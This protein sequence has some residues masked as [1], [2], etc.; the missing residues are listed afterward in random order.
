MS[1]LSGEQFFKYMPYP[2]ETGE[3]GSTY[4]RWMHPGEYEQAKKDGHFK[5]DLFM[6]KD[7]QGWL[8]YSMG[9]NDPRILVQFPHEDETYGMPSEHFRHY[10]RTQRPIAFEKATIT[11]ANEEGLAKQYGVQHVV[12]RGDMSNEERNRLERAG[13]A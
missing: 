9:K 12:G 10:V 4:S 6:T 5:K 7:K 13:I 8:E 2:E 11:H 3:H 1:N